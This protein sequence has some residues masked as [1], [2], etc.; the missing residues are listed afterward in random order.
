MERI[1]WR[2]RIDA[3]KH[4]TMVEAIGVAEIANRQLTW[5]LKRPAVLAERCRPA[6]AAENKIEPCR[7]RTGATHDESHSDS[8]HLRRK[9]PIGH[10]ISDNLARKTEDQRSDSS[11]DL[12][13]YQSLIPATLSL[14]LPHKRGGN[15]PAHSDS[16]PR[17][18]RPDER[19]E[20]AKLVESRLS[21]GSAPSTAAMPLR[22]RC[23]RRCSIFEVELACIPSPARRAH[24]HGG[25]LLIDTVATKK[26]APAGAPGKFASPRYDALGGMLTPSST[27]RIRPDAGCARSGSLPAS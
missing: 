17:P 16:E 18:H 6:M 15:R 25:S 12:S 13:D 20:I 23:A 11:F 1:A 10:C 14:T 24:D 7:T 21:S 2:D 4:R 5:G 8:A 3:V 27:S 26:G 9:P 19:R 22:S